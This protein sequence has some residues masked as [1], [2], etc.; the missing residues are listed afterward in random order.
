MNYTKYFDYFEERDGNGS[1]SI[2]KKFVDSVDDP[3]GEIARIPDFKFSHF[4]LHYGY[5]LEGRLSAAQSE[6]AWILTSQRVHRYL[7][8]PGFDK[9]PHHFR[10]P[11]HD[12]DAT[13]PSPRVRIHH[14]FRLLTSSDCL[15][16]SR[17]QN[18][19]SLGISVT[20]EWDEPPGGIIESIPLESPVLS[21][22]CIGGLHA[23][24]G[25]NLLMF[26]N[27]W[28]QDWGH[29]GDGMINSGLID[30][31]IVECWAISG[32]SAFPPLKSK[33]G[34]VTLLWKS[35]NGG[36]EVHGREIVDAGSGERIGWCFLVRRGE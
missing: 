19:Y 36:Q 21:T 24:P 22:H 11:N 3:V 23:V 4:G 12:Y 29:E 10:I 34:L 35:S 2:R 20:E 28:G 1:A 5:A 30:R 18:A 27:S 7:G 8:D 25:T 32:F 13:P 9:W 15:R 26:R 33:S 6:G 31:Y 17:T 16:M 14:Y